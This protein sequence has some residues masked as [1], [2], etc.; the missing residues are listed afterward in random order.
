MTRIHRQQQI[1]ALKVRNLELACPQFCHVVA[2]SRR[3]PERARIR[4]LADVVTVGRGRID[5]DPPFQSTQPDQMPGD[6]F[7]SR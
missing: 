2:A 4:R 3:K 1:K 7:R 5:L 6:R